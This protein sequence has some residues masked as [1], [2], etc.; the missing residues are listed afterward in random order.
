[1]SESL[2]SEDMSNDVTFDD[3]N[4]SFDSSTGNWQVTF[5][6]KL[7]TN[8]SEDN[9]LFCGDNVIVLAFGPR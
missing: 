3:T 8:D 5:S 7:N 9:E 6:R 1:M 2:P 4:S